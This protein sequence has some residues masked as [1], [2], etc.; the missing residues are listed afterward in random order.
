MSK[1]TKKRPATGER[2]DIDTSA[3]EGA[4]A[5]KT[6]NSESFLER[7]YGDQSKWLIPIVL[8]FGCVVIY[9]QTKSFDFVN[10]DDPSYVYKNKYVLGGL[11]WENIKW[12]FTAFHSAN[13]H[14]LTW[15]SHQLDISLFGLNA[16]SHHLVNVLLHTANSIL[17]FF[18][19]RKLTGSTWKSGVV[20]AIFAFH[21]AHVESVAWVSERKDVLSTLFWLLTVWFYTKYGKEEKSLKNYILAFLCCAI[22]LTAKPMLVTL[23]FVLLLLDFWPLERLDKI[24]LK[25]VMPLLIEKIPFFLLVFGSSVL[26]FI[27]QRGGGAVITLEFLPYSSRLINAIISYARYIGMAFYPVGLGGWYPYSETGYPL[28]QILISCALLVFVTGAS[29]WWFY[30]KRYLF[31]GWFWY[32]GTLVPVIGLVQ[33][34][35]QSHADRYTYIPYIGLTIMLVWLVAGLTEKLKI[36]K[37]VIGVAVL[38]FLVAFSVLSFRQVSYWR[39]NETFYTR[40]LAVTERNYLF[41]Q[42]YCQYLLEGERIE[43]AEIQCRNS[44]ANKSTYSNAWLSLGLIQM[45]QKKYSDALESF[46]IASRLRPADVPS[47]SNYINALIA[48]ERY[49]EAAQKTDLMAASDLPAEQVTPYL[50]PL[51]GQL[52]FI[53]AGKNE[54]EKAIAMGR[55]AVTLKPGDNDLR[56]NLGLL[57]YKGG[58]PVDAI[59]ELKIALDQNP[60]QVD[61]QVALGKIYF[62]TNRM[63]EAEAAFEKAREIDPNTRGVSEYLEKIKA[64][65]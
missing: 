7:T 44:I 54:I 14:P 20:A 58:N 56:A 52:S 5:D 27:A 23:P 49:D 30:S 3:G 16:G 48:L 6:G 32:V 12:A 24:S 22:G 39:N 28:W 51:Y 31:V 4:M 11:T 38:V 17:L 1:N 26:T 53:Y 21:P 55:K 34:G 19:I 15:L 63:P 8:I 43:E 37:D 29:I 10:F 45:K 47:F 25:A 61:L 62:D 42:N 60:R 50:I 33:V 13:W 57:L 65:K 46:E 64:R 41:E 36:N 35:R 59:A 40:T 2:V 9:Y 18:T